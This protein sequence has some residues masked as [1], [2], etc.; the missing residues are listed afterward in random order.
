MQQIK[1]IFKKLLFN[2][3]GSVSIYAI[4]IILPIFLLNA[5]FIDTMRIYVAERKMESAMDAALRSTMA[6]FDSKLAGLGLFAYKGSEGDASSDFT[7]Y[8]KK[9]SLGEEDLLGFFNIGEPKI[10]FEAS[11]ISFDSDRNL[12]DQDVFLSQIIES[13][14]Y[15]APVQIGSD[16]FDMFDKN[17]LKKDDVNKMQDLV[18]DYEEILKIMKKRN[19]KIDK[20]KK[21]YDLF[22]E[23]VNNFKNKLVGKSVEDKK[24]TI[25]KNLSTF[26]DFKAY[27]A[28]FTELMNKEELDD[29]EEKEIENYTIAVEGSDIYRFISITAHYN[30]IKANLIGKNG[31]LASPEDKTGKSYN[32]EV[33]DMMGADVETEEFEELG[34][35]VLDDAFFKTIL[36]STKEVYEDIM[37]GNTS[38][39]LGDVNPNTDFTRLTVIELATVFHL[40]LLIPSGELEHTFGG[41]DILGVIIQAMDDK[42]DKYKEKF[43]GNKKHWDDF[44]KIKDEF[45]NSDVQAEED[46]MDASFSDLIETIN[47]IRDVGDDQDKYDELLGYVDE[48]AGA[49]ADGSDIDDSGIFAFIKGAFD[50]FSEFIEFV[51]GFPESIRNELYVNEYILANFGTEKPYSIE[52]D[53]FYKYD[54]KKGQYITYGHHVTSL[55]YFHFVMD[56]AILFLVVNILNQ[57]KTKGFAGPFGFYSSLALALGETVVELGKFLEKGYLVWNPFKMLTKSDGI[58]FTGTMFLRMFLGVKSMS[59]SFNEDKIRRLQAAITLE[60]KRNLIDSP[61]YIE[62]NIQGEIDLWFIPQIVEVLPG[63]VEG[64]K[65]KIEKKKVYS[66]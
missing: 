2:K 21:K 37:K 19:N 52:S 46:K 42:F 8:L 38:I 10:D 33:I 12:V 6:K 26:H 20:A 47:A 60:T 32:N 41:D 31:S 62:G 53:N 5:L 45:K 48:Y 25:P 7:S 30:D 24:D 40:A 54:T 43:E 49:T 34:K 18:D 64:N 9:G 28:R 59:P 35:L 4:I 61:S 66:Y 50:R 51:N 56:I 63:K 36:D 23:Q 57:L 15:Q 58:K 3:Q 29:D 16:I 27:H 44:K 17:T 14:K 55:N 39:A 1:N 13:M 65:Y 22:E 11:S